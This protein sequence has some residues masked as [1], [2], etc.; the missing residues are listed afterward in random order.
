MKELSKHNIDK[1]VK[2]VNQK[3]A[4]DYAYPHNDETRLNLVRY[5]SPEK[6]PRQT[7][8]SHSDSNSDINTDDIENFD[9]VDLNHH[10]KLK[11]VFSEKPSEAPP[12]NTTM[13]IDVSKFKVNG[14][15]KPT[16][17]G[18]N[19]Q[20]KGKWVGDWA[21]F[22]CPYDPGDEMTQ[23]VSTRIT[24]TCLERG[25]LSIKEGPNK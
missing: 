9:D 16:N 7:E 21:H 4:Q 17:Y 2:D 1:S 6:G 14:E 11:I 12:P 15:Y 8:A 25:H 19:G 18:V 20:H 3:R 13:F 5:K 23:D 24:L 22:L 10:K